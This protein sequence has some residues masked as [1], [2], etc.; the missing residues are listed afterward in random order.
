MRLKS[1]SLLNAGLEKFYVA[2][3]NADSPEE[4]IV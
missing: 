4:S 3:D 1:K 2:F